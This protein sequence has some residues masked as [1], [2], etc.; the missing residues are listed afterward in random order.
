MFKKFF[1]IFFL[2]GLFFMLPNFAKAT[3]IIDDVNGVIGDGQNVTIAGSGFGTKTTAA[4]AYFF[5]NQNNTVGQLPVNLTSSST[6]GGGFVSTDNE[7]VVGTPLVKWN[8]L[9]T[10]PTDEWCIANG[11]SAGCNCESWGRDVFDFGALPIITQHYWT[12]WA[13]LDRSGT[14]CP[15]WQWKFISASPSHEGYFTYPDEAG[16]GGMWFWDDTQGWFGTAYQEY[17]S[18]YPTNNGYQ[19]AG[20]HYQTSGNISADGWLWN[21]WQRME[22][23]EKMSDDGTGVVYMNRVGRA[24]A[25]IEFHTNW[26]NA[27]PGDMAKGKRYVGVGMAI[28]S[29]NNT[30]TACNGS[31]KTVDFKLY[32]DSLYLD[33]TQA[34]VEICDTDAWTART[35]CEIQPTTAW[36]TVGDPTAE[37][38]I[39][40]NQG[41]FA[42]SSDAYLYVVDENGLVNAA[43]FPVILGNVAGDAI[44]PGA[45]S[46]L[47]VL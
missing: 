9:C 29:I 33:S 3:P 7:R 13:Y 20:N 17:Y 18:P 19:E 43:G 25:P 35:H 34:R 10:A 16:G 40:A 27:G 21:Q 14:T 28:A 31:G 26:Y 8:Y 15:R 32:N 1:K 22:F 4:P 12:M 47:S 6:E 41:T 46:G 44:A 37:I 36:P 23:Y 5:G 2:L 30:P 24:G 45:P 39:T 42:N 38:V 11:H